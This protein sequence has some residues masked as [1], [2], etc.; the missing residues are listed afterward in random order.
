MDSR[1]KEGSEEHRMDTDYDRDTLF[2]SLIENIVDVITIIDEEGVIRYESPSITGMLGYA[3]AEL[4]GE[5]VFSFVHKDDVPAVRDLFQ[6][7]KAD[8]EAGIRGGGRAIEVR[9]KHRD[10]TWRTLE[11]MVN[12]LD[13]PGVRGFVINSHDITVRKQ[14]EEDIRRLNAELE[15]KIRERTSELEHAAGMLQEQKNLLQTIINT[16]PVIVTLWNP[17]GKLTLVNT[18]FE[19]RTGWSSEEALRMDILAAAFPDPAYR[20]KIYRQVV[21]ADPGWGE[22]V[23]TTRSGRTTTVSWAAVRLPDNSRIGIGIDV[24]ERRVMEKDLL[25]LA[26]AV[27]QAGEGIAIF[28][29]EGVIEYVNPAY[30]KISGYSP[31]EMVGKKLSSLTEYLAGHDVQEILDRLAEEGTS[32][33]GRQKRRRKTGELID[34]SLAITPVHDRS[35]DVIDFLAVIQDITEELRVQGQ[36]AQ[37]QKMEAVGTLAG[38]IAHDLKNILTPILLNTE[39]ALED[40][41]KGHPAFPVLEEALDAARL[42][43][44]LVNQILAFSRRGPREKAPVNIAGVVRETV[45]FLRSTL[46]STIDI[47]SELGDDCV[48]AHAEPTQIKQVLLNLGSNAAQAMRENGGTLEVTEAS[49]TLDAW[50]TGRISPDLPGGAYVRIMVCDTG[51][52]MDETTLE[53]IFEPF[54]T[55]RKDEGTGMGLALVHSIVK[56][57]RGAVTVRSAPGEGTAF[58]VLLPVLQGGR[59]NDECTPAGGG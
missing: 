3:Q 54:F 26:A 46:P 30:E 42:G 53:H 7:L 33:S 12:I 17:E 47:R 56:D 20:R 5:D 45:A 13:V 6:E 10:G 27:D 18:E 38:G 58:T 21:K 39:M 4:I 37:T 49:V 19:E 14:A 44:D 29:P 24:T 50:E 22:F 25:R 9:I 48:L 15:Q 11:S 2:Q 32:W 51:H 52:G 23:M 31:D 36:L 59:K 34:I 57:H 40:V 16:I 8:L 35:G 1:M 43:R 41:G 55:T 28:S